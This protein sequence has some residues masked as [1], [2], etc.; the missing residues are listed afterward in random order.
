MNYGAFN[1]CV[2]EFLSDCEGLRL[3][4]Q[5]FGE[6]YERG[7]YENCKIEFGPSWSEENILE[8]KANMYSDL[9][10]T[11]ICRETNFVGGS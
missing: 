2:S 3:N 11:K 10:R 8:C 9:E 6:I 5:L 1:D 7:Y 4:E